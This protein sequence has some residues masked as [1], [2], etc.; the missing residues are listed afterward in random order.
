[1]NWI[2]GT[3]ALTA[4]MTYLAMEA[5]TYKDRGNGLRSY[6]KAFRT[7]LLV[8]VP[9]FIISGLFYYLF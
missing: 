7:S 1:M 4:V 6:L 2:L 8:L 3:L 9:F 5:A